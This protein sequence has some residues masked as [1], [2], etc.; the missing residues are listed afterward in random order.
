MQEIVIVIEVL[1]EEG[2]PVRDQNPNQDHDRDHGRDRVHVPAQDLAVIVRVLAH[3]DAAHLI[4]GAFVPRI[5]I[6]RSGSLFP[7]IEA[8]R[9]LDRVPDREADKCGHGFNLTFIGFL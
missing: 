2:G 8:G 3:H 4:A 1:V 6:A 9:N 5:N 7:K